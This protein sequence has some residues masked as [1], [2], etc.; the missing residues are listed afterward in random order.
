MRRSSATGSPAPLLRRARLIALA[1][2]AFLAP[3]CVLLA[4]TLPATAR[5]QNVSAWP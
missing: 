3:W 4:F 1:V 2:G 5:A